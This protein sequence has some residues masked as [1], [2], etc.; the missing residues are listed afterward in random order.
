MV[1]GEFVQH[2]IEQGVEHMYV[3][4][5]GS[6]DDTKA[7][8][9]PHIASGFISYFYM[10]E[11]KSQIS[12]YNKVYTSNARCECHWVMVNDVDEY[13]FGVSKPF[14]SILMHELSEHKYLKLQMLN[15]GSSGHKLQPSNIRCE[16][17]LRNAET[18]IHDAATK[19]TFRTDEVEHLGIHVHTYAGKPFDVPN[20]LVRFNHYK[21]MSEEYWQKIKMTRSD[22]IF[23]N[24]VVRNMTVFYQTDDFAN[25]EDNTLKN[26]VLNGYTQTQ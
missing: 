9:Q 3:I 22:A 5:N 6:T 10:P 16:F 25:I 8:L 26:I 20:S 11:P 14:K 18:P 17:T 15:F 23:G 21:I 24:E 1:I 12:S 13:V 4:D 19:A 7:V 2:Y